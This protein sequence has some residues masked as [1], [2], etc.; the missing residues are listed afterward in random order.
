MVI[1]SRDDFRNETEKEREL[2][3]F[4]GEPTT[5][6]KVLSGIKNVASYVAN[7]LPQV[8]FQ[9][10]AAGEKPKIPVPRSFDL[11]YQKEQADKE[12]SYFGIRK[13]KEQK[14]L[15][16]FFGPQPD[17]SFKMQDIGGAAQTVVSGAIKESANILQTMFGMNP[18]LEK[19]D[20]P[21]VDEPVDLNKYLFPINRAGLKVIDFVNYMGAKGLQKAGIAH[22][23][24]R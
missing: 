16:S 9:A 8:D 6:E 5:G 11:E 22:E 2:R 3:L 1:L 23:G 7:Q 14:E 15:E 18:K 12:L 17:P 13:T 10:I 19:V 4:F 24:K 20:V 21:F